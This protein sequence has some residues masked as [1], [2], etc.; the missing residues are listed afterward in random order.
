MAAGYTV[1]LLGCHWQRRRRMQRARAPWWPRPRHGPVGIEARLA[2]THCHVCD[3][4][5]RPGA[6]GH[7]CR[8][9]TS[10]GYMLVAMARSTSITLGDHF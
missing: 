7:P 6:M 9:D 1:V 10:I 2:L 8:R 4:R 3:V 5:H